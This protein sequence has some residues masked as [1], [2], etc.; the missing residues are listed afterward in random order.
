MEKFKFEGRKFWAKFGKDIDLLPRTYFDFVGEEKYKEVLRKYDLKD[1]QVIDIGA[2]YPPPKVLSEEKKSA[3]LGSELQEALEN[4]GAKIIAVDVANEPLKHQKEAG[5]LP[6]LGSVFELPFEEESIDG[7]A[8][9]LNLFNSSFKPEREEKEIF[10][11]PEE[12]KEILEEAYRVLQKG[13]FLIINNYGYTIVKI[14]NL[15]II[16]PEENEIITPELIRKLAEEVGFQHIE[17]I[18]FDKNRVTLGEK[19][20]FGSFPE[21][22]RERMTIEA[23]AGSA[24]LFEK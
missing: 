1:K 8:I 20:M 18:P 21:T 11:K 23:K 22:L 5:R 13:T 16:G 10:M 7:G 12:C 24:L 9:I 4:K 2:G 3:P 15:K 19:L 6:V 14:D 17:D